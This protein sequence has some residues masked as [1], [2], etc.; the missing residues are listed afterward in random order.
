MKNLIVAIIFFTF[1]GLTSYE[2][3]TNSLKDMKQDDDFISIISTK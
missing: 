3:Y 2:I 1:L